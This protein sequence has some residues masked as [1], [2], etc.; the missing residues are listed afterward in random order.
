MNKP[1]VEVLNDVNDSEVLITISENKIGLFGGFSE[2]V[3]ILSS[4]LVI[5][6]PLREIVTEAI[7]QV[8]ELKKELNSQ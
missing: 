8:T 4:A 3:G 2:L 1:K 7:K 5:N 6:E